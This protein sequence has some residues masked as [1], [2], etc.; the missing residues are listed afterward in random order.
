VSLQN[1]FTRTSQRLLIVAVAV[2]ATIGTFVI[3]L[4]DYQT[5]LYLLGSFFVPLF[6]VLFADWLWRGARYEP[7]DFFAGPALRAAPILAWL[8]GFAL[9]QWLAPNGPGWWIQLAAH[10]HPRNVGFTASLPSFAAAFVLTT[11]IR[12]LDS[13]RAAPRARRQPLARSR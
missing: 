3:N 12:A 7:D 13:A 9:Y 6:G 11:A 8:V 10:A 1:V 4:R 5:F 2:T